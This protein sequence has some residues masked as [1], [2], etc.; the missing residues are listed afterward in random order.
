MISE[1]GSAKLW[2]VEV[3]QLWPGV[4]GR[5]AGF[6]QKFEHSGT[7][8]HGDTH[9]DALTHSTDGVF[10][11]KICSLRGVRKILS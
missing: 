10:L 5:A 4:D 7:Q 8:T 9:N 1:G 11:A 2:S 6:V 3:Q